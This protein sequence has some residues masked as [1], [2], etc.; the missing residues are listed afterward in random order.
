MRKTRALLAILTLA[1]F[2]IGCES[3]APKKAPEQ[4]S[5]LGAPAEPNGAAANPN[6][7]P[8]HK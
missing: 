5:D 4:P 2:A 8:P 1:A 6:P 3:E 7:T